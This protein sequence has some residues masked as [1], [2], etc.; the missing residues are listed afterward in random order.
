MR[1]VL[2]W[3]ALSVPLQGFAS[4][5]GGNGG[6]GSKALDFSR[7]AYKFIAYLEQLPEEAQEG[8]DAATLRNALD[9]AFI[10]PVDHCI[11]ISP[12]GKEFYPPACNF[13]DDTP[14]RIE[15]ADTWTEQSE[16]EKIGIAGHEIAGLLKLEINTYKLTARIMNHIENDQSL[17]NNSVLPTLLHQE[18]ADNDKNGYSEESVVRH[19]NKMRKFFLKDNFFVYCHYIKKHWRSSE[20]ESILVP[21][22]KFLGYETFQKISSSTAMVGAL[23][24]KVNRS[25]FRSRPVVRKIYR[26]VKVDTIRSE[27]IYGIKIFGLGSF[28]TELPV[29]EWPHVLLKS[30]ALISAPD[31]TEHQEI[32]LLSKTYP[33]SPTAYQTCILS[34]RVAMR[35][36]ISKYY[37]SQCAIGQSVDGSWY[38]EIKTQNPFHHE[39]F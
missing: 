32:V 39:D 17:A 5:R 1:N 33:N 38:F 3:L 6:D 14:Q 35:E 27:S 36:N 24:A 10:K 2:L 11:A 26:E 29:Y 37:R 18:F 13:P 28:N 23:F 19:C 16:I 12:D 9:S 22:Y 31:A 7:S 8:L 34:L 21:G 4:T 20:V 15:V 25:T 30:D